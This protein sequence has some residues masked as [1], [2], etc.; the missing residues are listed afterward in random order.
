MST[1][2]N[3]MKEEHAR[4]VETEASYAKSIEK[5]P[6]GAPRIKRIRNGNYLYLERRVGSKVVDEYIG[7]ADSDKA[8]K[9]LEKIKK[10]KRLANLLKETRQA[11][12][13]VKRVLRGKI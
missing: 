1:I 11:L 9:V 4:L 5:L 3:I 2:F 12:K 6:K 8:K 13:D 10:R 7:A